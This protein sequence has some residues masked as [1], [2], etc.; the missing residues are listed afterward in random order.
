[1]H[2]G[3]RV[4][5]GEDGQMTLAMMMLAVAVLAVGVTFFVFGQATDARGTAQ[6]AADSG[7]L[8]AADE[9]RDR[10]ARAWVST[11]IVPESAGVSPGHD[12]SHSLST[13]AGAGQEA[14]RAKAAQ[15]AWRNDESAVEEYAVFA[16]PS[17]T[18]NAIHVSV[19]TQS[20]ELQSVDAGIGPLQG[21][22]D[23]TAE[24]RAA[25]PVTCRK[26]AYPGA[27]T[28]SGWR[29]QCSNTDGQ[30]ASAYYPST[31]QTPADLPAAINNFAELFDVR[32]V[33]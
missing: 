15:F 12:H 31:S 1:M 23:A 27:G 10:W 8:A 14:S 2:T 19:G 18:S 3:E 22:A 17:A 30:S 28:I 32:L 6:K 11:Q 20:P 26:E 5:R 33:D 29:L 9:M 21:E 4:C 24:I 7:A 25:S 13:A 16:S